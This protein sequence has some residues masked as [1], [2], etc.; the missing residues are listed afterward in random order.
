MQGRG[1][2]KRDTPRSVAKA[3]RL[4]SEQEIRLRAVF[5]VAQPHR[6]GLLAVC[7]I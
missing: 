5:Q 4:S 3:S 2:D 7:R 1:G 6:Q